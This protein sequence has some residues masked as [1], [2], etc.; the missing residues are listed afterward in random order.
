MI[1]LLRK[2]AMEWERR[3]QRQQCILLSPILLRGEIQKPKKLALT[4]YHL[5]GNLASKKTM[6]T[7]GAAGVWCSKAI[8]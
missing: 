1:L 3:P 8:S 6:M 7:A 4:N 2:N 5:C